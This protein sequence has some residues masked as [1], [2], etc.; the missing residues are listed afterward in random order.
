[1]SMA[2]FCE[3]LVPTGKRKLTV[4]PASALKPPPMAEWSGRTPGVELVRNSSLESR[5]RRLRCTLSTK[6]KCV[7]GDGSTLITR[8]RG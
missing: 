8:M 1:M 5:R 3:S 4:R 6:K 2:A 7:G